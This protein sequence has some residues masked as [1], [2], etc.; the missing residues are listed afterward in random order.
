MFEDPHGGASGA[1][2]DQGERVVDAAVGVDAV[3]DDQGAA[4]GFTS[5]DDENFAP[6]GWGEKM[7]RSLKSFRS[8]VAETWEN[9]DG[10]LGG[11]QLVMG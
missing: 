2:E 8:I 4:W 5:W 3:A 11:F 6:M 10:I 9:K 7:I 1:I